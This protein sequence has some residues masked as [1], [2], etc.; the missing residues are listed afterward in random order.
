MNKIRNKLLLAIALVTLI[1]LFGLGWYGR[2]ATVTALSTVGVQ[3]LETRISVLSAQI[4][5]FLSGMTGDLFLLSEAASL[6]QLFMA[7][8]SLDPRLISAAKA[9]LA[10]DFLSMSRNRKVYSQIRF[11]DKIGNE[12]IRVDNA[13]DTTTVVPGNE[14]QNKK[15]RYYFKETV[16]KSKGEVT[17]SPLDLNRERGEV[18]QPLQPVLR[19][20]TPVFDEKQ[21][22]RGIIVL[23]VMADQILSMVERSISADETLLFTD[24][25]GFYLSHPDP[26]KRWGGPNDLNT[27]AAFTKDYPE[28]AQKL[29]ETPP[30]LKFEN[31][32]SLILAKPIV[33][34]GGKNHRLGVLVDFVPKATVYAAV[35]DFSN[36]F[37]ILSLVAFALTIGQG[38]VVASYIT[39]PILYLTE[40]V[41]GMSR[42]E[43]DQ[44]I[45]VNTQDET[46]LL[47]MAIERLRKSMKVMLDKFS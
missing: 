45:D 11:I 15:D 42:G 19:Y 24:P 22:L 38:T 43:L 32:G 39:G 6:R 2:Y 10:Q 40:A 9:N 7:L 35:S 18:Q 17:I 41:E 13:G 26:K 25:D 31:E 37:D 21:E 33:I 3:K 29:L 16:E 27:G 12:V 8:D 28:V 5:G 4:E 20:G 1:P 30:Q 23:N 44:A 47:A 34:P 14:L 36:L 46:K